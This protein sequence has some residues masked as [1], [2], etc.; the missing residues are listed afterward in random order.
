MKAITETIGVARSHQ[1]GKTKGRGKRYDK[2]EDETHLA[3][4]RSITDRRPSY[5]YRRTTILVNRMLE[6][7]GEPWINH[8]RVYRL[9]KLHCLLLERH[10]GRPIIAHEGTIITLKSDMRWCS[11]GFEIPCQTGAR[12][13]VVFAMD[14][15]DREALGYVATTG[16]IT[17]EMVRDLMAL[18]VENRFGAALPRMIE[19][20]SDNG[21]A[22]TAHETRSFARLIGLEPRTTPYYSPES[23]GMAEAFVKTFKRDYVSFNDCKTPEEVME[24]LPVWFEDYNECHPHKGL[25]MK[26]PRE[27]RRMLAKQEACPV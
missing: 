11:D 9:M 16:G 26:S 12:V 4:I 20:L 23:N 19:W 25:K 5:G 22:Y 7:R 10:T 15:S 14:C 27:Y 8:K 3:L 13:R 18:A 24:R 1:Y 17:G 2:P 6:E 21:P